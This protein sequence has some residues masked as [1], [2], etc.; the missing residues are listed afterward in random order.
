MLF[1]TKKIRIVMALALFLTATVFSSA[2]FAPQPAMAQLPVT[3]PSNVSKLGMDVK[4]T[5]E[6][7]QKELTAKIKE[8]GLMMV[9]SSIASAVNYFA[10][11][12]A[13]DMGVWL[14]SGGKGQSPFS[15]GKSFGN[16]MAQVA[17]DSLGEAL[18]SLG[19]SLGLDLC[20][21][22][23][24]R[25][26]LALKLGLHFNYEPPKP[27]CSF[28][29]LKNA[30]NP[31]N[32]RSQYASKE[33]LASRI[34]MGVQ[35]DDTEMGIAVKT[36]ATVD[37]YAVEKSAG[38]AEDRKEGQG[39]SA[40]TEIISGKQTVP[41]TVMKEEMA[42][43]S[44]ANKAKGAADDRRA[45]MGAA[46][47]KGGIS[48]AVN[49][50]KTFVNT[51]LGT[52]VNNFLTK[53]MLP[54]GVK[55]C[56][57]GL[58]ISGVNLEPCGK[59]EGGSSVAGDYYSQGGAGGAGQRRA[60]Q[61]MFAELLMPKI[62]TMD[63]YDPTINFTDCSEEN[64]SPDA[65]VMDDSF[66]ALLTRAN[67]GESLTIKQAMEQTGL[68]PDRPLLSEA[69]QVGKSKLDCQKNFYCL[70]NIQFLRLLRI[71]PLGFEIAAAISGADGSQPD[72]LRTVVDNYYNHSSK[73]YGLVNPYWVI[74]L[75]K[76]RCNALAYS[77]ISQEGTHFPTCADIQHCVSNN[78]DGSC[79]SWGYCLREQPFW[80]FNANYCDSQFNTCRAFTSSDGASGSYLVRTLDTVKCTAENSGCRR[81]S[82][83]KFWNSATS[84][85][86]FGATTTYNSG[87]NTFFNSSIHLNSKA[88]ACDVASDGC[89]AYKL[90][91]DQTQFVYLRKAPDYLGCYD[92]DT[93]VGTNVMDL[94]GKKL[95]NGIQWPATFADLSVIR[96]QNAEACQKYAQVCLPEEEN[97]DYYTSALTRETVPG[98]FKPAVVA[99]GQVTWNDQCDAKCVGYAA[100][101]EMPGNYSNGQILTYIIPSSGKTCAAADA[102]CAAFTNLSTTAGGLQQTEY[103]S[104]LRPCMLPD[105][106]KQ[107]NYYVYESS[108]KGGYQLKT[109]TLEKDGSASGSPKQ[110]FRDK[111]EMDKYAQINGQNIYCGANSYSNNTADPD[112]H[113]FI[114]DAGVISYALLGKTVVVSDKCTPYR[115]DNNELTA[116]TS[117]DLRC[118]FDFDPVAIANQRRAGAEVVELK[119][120]ACY[121]MGLTDS[122]NGAGDT[123]SCTKEADTCHAYKGNAGNN[124]RVLISDTF[125]NASTSDWVGSSAAIKISVSSESTQLSGHSMR[126]AATVVQSDNIYPYKANIPVQK[127]K[128]YILSFW[129]KGNLPI[130]RIAMLGTNFIQI[131][132][133]STISPSDVWRYYSFGPVEYD[134]D[135]TT[136][137]FGLRLGSTAAGQEQQFFIDNIKFSEVEDYLYLVKNSLSVDPIC[138]SSPSDN[139][140][141][142]ALGCMA[143]AT[144]AKTTFNLTNFSYL[145]R[146]AAVGC[147]ALLDTFNTPEDAGA[148]AY[149][150]WLKGA[151]GIASVTV[152][153]GTFTCSVPTGET[154]CYTN[155]FGKTI[156][157]LKANSQILLTSS[158]VYI[159]PDT[160]S[161]APIYLVA[162][163][164]ATCKSENMGCQVVGLS[165][166][167]VS[168]KSYSFGSSVY[169][170]PETF[171]EVA[172]KNDPFLYDTALCGSE[173]VG[174]K[175][176]VS[177]ES[178]YYFKDPVTNG[179]KICEFK[180][181]P[182]TVLD[183]GV[184]PY[185]LSSSTGWIWKDTG[186]CKNGATYMVRLCSAD[187]DCVIGS[188]TGTCQ[189]KNQLACY[190]SRILVNNQWEYQLASYGNTTTYKGFVGACPQEQSGC[191]EF[192]DHS[193]VNGNSKKCVYSGKRCQYDSE[194]NEID[195]DSCVTTPA[196]AYY[197]IDDVKLTEAQSKCG[198][199]AS[200]AEGCVL[201]DR[202]SQ[203]NKFWHTA[204]TYAASFANKDAMVDPSIIDG[205]NDAN[206]IM[207][208]EHDRECAEWAYCNLKQ[209][210]EDQATGEKTSRC[211]RLGV[212][213]K[214]G[215]GSGPGASGLEIKECV[216]TIASG[217][218]TDNNILN[219]D[220]YRSLIGNQWDAK[221]FSGYSTYNT[222][223]LPDI[224][225]RKVNGI[226]RLVFVD[227][228]WGAGVDAP[229]NG[230]QEHNRIVHQCAP[231]GG[232]SQGGVC[233]PTGGGRECWN[234]ECLRNY[235]GGSFPLASAP[236]IDCRAYADAAAP[237]PP[238]A[239]SNETDFAEGLKQGFENASMCMSA[240]GTPASC[241]ADSYCSYRK[242]K[243]TAGDVFKPLNEGMKSQFVCADGP[244][245]GVYCDDPEATSTCGGPYCA[246]IKTVQT[247]P[248][249]MGY[250]M[251]RDV[252]QKINGNPDSN[253]CLTWWPIQS[254]PGVPTFWESDPKAGYEIA[255]GP[256]DKVI[257]AINDPVKVDDYPN[258][259]IA[260]DTENSK[261]DEYEIDTL[262]KGM[263]IYDAGRQ[264]GTDCEYDV[265]QDFEIP[266]CEGLAIIPW[267]FGPPEN[268]WGYNA[269]T[270]SFKDMC[271]TKCDMFYGDDPEGKSSCSDSRRP[272]CDLPVPLWPK[273]QGYN[274]YPACCEPASEGADGMGDHTSFAVADIPANAVVF[275]CYNNS[276]EASYGEVPDG[277]YDWLL[278]G[279]D[280][281]LDSQSR[282]C[283]INSETIRVI[284]T[285]DA[286][287]NGVQG[288]KYC[289]DQSEGTFSNE[290]GE[291][292]C[293]KRNILSEDPSSLISGWYDPS[294]ISRNLISPT[295]YT[296]FNRNEIERID[297][298]FG[299]S[300]DDF[301]GPVYNGYVSFI[302]D[303][304]G[305]DTA[306]NNESQLEYGWLT[307][308]SF[309]KATGVEIK[310]E[311]VDLGSYS[312]ECNNRYYNGWTA[313]EWSAWKTEGSDGTDIPWD[314]SAD[315]SG[316]REEIL[317]SKI[318]NDTY[319]KAD[320]D[321]SEDRN[322]FGIRI[323]W[324]ENKDLRGIW[325]NL[326]DGE[327]KSAYPVFFVMHFNNSKCSANGGLVQVS[328]IFDEN[329]DQRY[330][331]TKPYT[332]LLATGTDIP[333]TIDSQF[334][335]YVRPGAD[336]RTPRT[337]FSEY[338]LLSPVEPNVFINPF[339]PVVGVNDF[340]QDGG[341]T[342]TAYPEFTNSNIELYGAGVPLTVA[343]YYRSLNSSIDPGYGNRSSGGGEASAFALAST[344][345]GDPY[346]NIT[347]NG[348]W[349]P[350][351]RMLNRMFARVYSIG[352]W[353][354]AS[355]P[356]LDMANPNYR[357][358]PLG[359]I[360]PPQ[361]A[362]PT[363]DGSW[364]LN[365]ISVNEQI[366]GNQYVLSGSQV[367]IKFYAWA[368]GNQMPIRKIVLSPT[369]QVNDTSLIT[370]ENESIGN[371]KY[372]CSG[373]GVCSI[374]P[375]VAS[376]SEASM[377]FPC[378]NNENCIPAWTGCF[379]GSL[380]KS[381]VFGNTKET[382]C[383]DKPWDFVVDYNCPS[384]DTKIVYY[385]GNN[386]GIAD[387]AEGL[388]NDG[389]AWSNRILPLL[390]YIPRFVCVAY[391]RVHVLDNWG[392]CTGNCDHGGIVGINTGCYSE[393][394]STANECDIRA[395][396]TTFVPFGNLVGNTGRVI[397]IPVE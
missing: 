244:L 235:S 182:I 368:H 188:A 151:P 312:V 191:S 325:L 385:D 370:M 134:Y 19:D 111:A 5:V 293:W 225:A 61:E 59:G 365:T 157:L 392:W 96:P 148:R 15:S 164:D 128:G 52:I 120:N 268:R 58:S 336:P 208:V 344:G 211:Y 141:G 95:A 54:G 302:P 133:S 348:T 71:L 10:N 332:R 9:M 91:S 394:N 82:L 226:W 147:V 80:K 300:G 97:C 267:Y 393:I 391:P 318:C 45:M 81:Y 11:K 102:G 79:A 56:N 132:S 243:T 172:V 269:E 121:Y 258:N 29:E 273:D 272:A 28:Q 154:G 213:E 306:Q 314:K 69:G 342:A 49:T 169:T 152:G 261:G 247:M 330:F 326:E 36:K 257:C 299:K 25:L 203:P 251:T 41:A 230:G 383:R 87:S 297:V 255:K 176:W 338:G 118:P 108:E 170:S 202:T 178:N 156:D 220:L 317:S 204:S 109:Y 395:T 248:G 127:G 311:T 259:V 313:W 125:E 228:V 249:W 343:T 20:K 232:V 192:I 253:A 104:Y 380:D 26:D 23:D 222:Y 263:S 116:Y 22:P 357:T 155:I 6:D 33:A 282:Y 66:L 65:C 37:A 17:G 292:G 122:T 180:S 229:I 331:S 72:T 287:V 374:A 234:G 238:T 196:S 117:T 354:A 290:N 106:T 150:V 93:S 67:T 158:T 40:M 215:A 73:Y 77:P 353:G 55:V 358:S 233:G 31:A 12:I 186:V 62:T 359:L 88:A 337:N 183:I 138:D 351:G 168:G 294:P 34:G 112:C 219:I 57:P 362:A 70:R 221:E 301:H 101:R 285:T 32:I 237:F 75:P 137:W 181:E 44:A 279:E 308:E 16:Y 275:G 84:T 214:A 174:C 50:L 283:P 340:S 389:I 320:F 397:I 252:R 286:G 53:G 199:M 13:Y 145:C 207:K 90:A 254:P 271:P 51:V 153:G 349:T 274:G 323:V 346:Y 86:W 264:R 303:A 159:P 103:F 200:M 350:F 304:I 356:Y 76:T 239:L 236:T 98:K 8:Q 7:K 246:A 113:Q 241:D 205:A 266:M 166:P 381:I 309:F 345:L 284:G 3:D 324:D 135:A 298:V 194:C 43:Q 99:N 130:T 209:I 144:P 139:L 217:W 218:D 375:D 369:G 21:L 177:G 265:A 64:L 386:N 361:V 396:S 110:I 339:T 107:K 347:A 173:A 316:E 47:Q 310:R 105:Q 83:A 371:R 388:Q 165:T 321:D 373:E 245:K 30:Y 163:K 355:T 193:S 92:A 35:V 341:N 333:M 74:K 46:L 379:K 89:S 256:Q 63:N 296:Y 85:G 131:I 126:V 250:C 185:S 305:A 334:S 276:G 335:S 277:Y 179:N 190:P 382:G 376:I 329:E 319:A 387:S 124:V 384:A 201:L 123:V 24:L 281:V 198:S 115:L 280:N 129:L 262:P 189:Y 48:I 289:T 378:S 364:A 377:Q 38:V 160:T 260:I 366:S 18:G 295:H 167:S 114:D 227:A 390:G 307:D 146:E 2:F 119:N 100:Y 68:N 14:A 212:C 231:T 136:T 184:T 291:G 4:K 278:G 270:D 352:G 142:E 328:S 372:A 360:Y 315:D 1:K 206:V 322:Q 216:N 143:Y 171:T 240:S 187:A 60:A 210:T 175:S 78:K 161:T 197:L 242:L 94:V 363:A 149:N 288:M 27:R 367:H 195:R 39:V 223:Q 42:A 327:G 224:S 162:S 140:P